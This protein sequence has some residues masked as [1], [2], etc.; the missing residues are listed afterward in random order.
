MSTF[1]TFNGPQGNG[2]PSTQAILQLID[3]YNEVSKTLNEHIKEHAGG[4]VD[5]HRVNEAI[6]SAK[7]ELETMIGGRVRSDDANYTDAVALVKNEDISKRA[8]LKEDIDAVK[9]GIDEKVAQL[10]TKKELDEKAADVELTNTKADVT[11]IRGKLNTLQDAWDKFSR[12]YTATDGQILAFNMAI[13]TLKLIG[14]VNAHEYI[15]FT[16]WTRVIAPFAGVSDVTNSNGLYVLGELSLDWDDMG[17]NNSPE[18]KKAVKAGRAFI[19]Y[20][21]TDSFDSIVDVTATH[22]GDN[23]NGTW[24]G[25]ITQHTSR[26]PSMWRN[27]S[28]HLMHSTGTDGKEHVYLCVSADGLANSN[29]DYS[30]LTFYVAGENIVPCGAKPELLQ[31]A[32]YANS[33]ENI[34]ATDNLDSALTQG[35]SANRVIDFHDWVR[36]EAKYV[37][38]ESYYN[39]GLPMISSD[40]DNFVIGI[41]SDADHFSGTSNV[42]KDNRFVKQCLVYIKHNGDE[43]FEATVSCTVE[44]TVDLNGNTK[45]KGT[46][47]PKLSRPDGKW[48]NISFHLETPSDGSDHV[49][50]AI[51]AD[52][53]TKS[54]AEIDPFVL[55]VCGVNFKPYGLGDIDDNKVTAKVN[56]FCTVNYDRI[57]YGTG[58]E[59]GIYFTS[60]PIVPVKDENDE[61]GMGTSPLATINDM[62]NSAVP[63]GGIV[64]WHKFEE[65]TKKQ[66]MDEGLEDAYK[67]HY[68]ALWDEILNDDEIVSR[69]AVDVP[70][71]YLP[72]DGRSFTAAEYPELA[73]KIPECKLP[74]QDYGMIHV[75]VWEND[76]IVNG[77]VSDTLTKERLNEKIEQETAA[78]KEDVLMLQQGY[79]S[80]DSLLSGKFSKAI[81]DETEARIVADDGIIEKF[82]TETERLQDVLDDVSDGLGDS[83][84]AETD[85]RKEADSNLYAEIT[86]VKT[87]LDAKQ[88]DLDAKQTELVKGLADET[89]ARKALDEKITDASNGLLADVGKRID[90]E[91]QA[92]NTRASTIEHALEEETDNRRKADD[93][94]QV[95]ID[96]EASNRV[97]ATSDL[98][99]QINRVISDFDAANLSSVAFDKMLSGRIDAVEN[100][101]S[102]KY[103]ATQA[104]DRTLQGNID[105]IAADLADEATE[106]KTED[107]KLGS[108]TSTL[109][110]GLLDEE[111]ARKSAD[112]NL[113]TKVDVLQTALDVEATARVN[114]DAQLQTAI[115]DEAYTR[116]KND[117]ILSGKF[118]TA[119]TAEALARADADSKL[120]G[121]IDTA[122]TN[123]VNVDKRVDNV[124]SDLADLE[125]AVDQLKQ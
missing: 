72:C 21:N 120:Q 6:K 52:Q 100:D 54:S 46:I 34:F 43:P 112:N 50:L 73:V 81:A 33:S 29:S 92:F 77:D 9:T 17:D 68:G 12:C 28:Y 61:S 42:T 45:W 18:G 67:E 97:T 88:T 10:A 48:R 91:V 119:I 22:Y 105:N 95:N 59:D 20:V 3:A 83:I 79:E 63:V 115:A 116:E 55:Y 53:L 121:K 36:T 102:V 117:E 19:K 23:V 5:V 7:T 106:R 76:N 107:S 85:A 4:D 111:T 62:L 35:I 87:D 109:E 8:A 98:Q 103:A 69:F 57:V 108:R 110:T 58:E 38:V 71:G 65:K 51:S 49:F 30:N 118:S 96:T 94:L 60:R 27:L 25:S 78:R 74:V 47:F 64:S 15:D 113:D 125:D 99:D 123:I 90:T 14:K 84:R 40:N 31:K 80:A 101:I 1:T 41:L 122:N 16:K 86:N 39:T 56:V 75:V 89:V 114:K 37:A 26:V 44:K 13:M 32:Q 11:D 82:T 2:M 93:A 66:V 70:D 104:A 24:V 124:A